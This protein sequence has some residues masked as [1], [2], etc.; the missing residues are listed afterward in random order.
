MI[1]SFISYSDQRVISPQI[2]LGKLTK[3]CN[4][5]NKRIQ[6][7]PP[8]AN[9]YSHLHDKQLPFWIINWM[10]CD[11]TRVPNT[12][13]LLDVKDT[14]HVTKHHHLTDLLLLYCFP[15]SFLPNCLTLV[16]SS[17]PSESQTLGA[18]LHITNL[19]LIS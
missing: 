7:K 14:V 9:T 15:C 1:N 4:C 8:L 17:T 18:L 12:W 19:P 13:L 6:L 11:K 5:D 16:A 10:I 2:T 3:K